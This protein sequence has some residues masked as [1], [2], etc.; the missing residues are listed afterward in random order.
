[1]QDTTQA[2]EFAKKLARE[3][4]EIMTQ[5][6]DAD[7]KKVE[8]K[9]N[10]SQVTIADKLINQ[11]VIDQV[12][13]KFPS[14]GVL[15]EEGSRHEDRKELWVCDPI[16]GTKG[17]ILGIPTAMFSL[18]FV[19]NGRPE[20]AALH[21]SKHATL[22]GAHIVGPAS[23]KELKDRRTFFDRLLEV[24][25][26]QL[27]VPGAVFR[28]SLVAGGGI[29]AHLFPGRSAHDIAAAKLVVEEAGGKVTDLYG[30]EQ[31]YDGRIYGAI[32]SN[33]H[34]DQTLT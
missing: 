26:S 29:E 5:Y 2:L 1:M 17:F 25:A 6:F 34:L 27:S 9:A 22:K 8:L 24:G 14:H 19:V 12:A 11:L 20:V 18:A 15:A 23:Y 32:I 28:S 33:G 7:D 4:A 30:K 21:V 31:R 10:A 13:A 3:A 16:D